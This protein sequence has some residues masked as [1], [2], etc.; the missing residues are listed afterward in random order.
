MWS[1]SGTV[2]LGTDY[3]SIKAY[4]FGIASERPVIGGSQAQSIIAG[5]GT[6]TQTVE[7][8]GVTITTPANSATG[9]VTEGTLIVKVKLSLPS[10]GTI[11]VGTP[12]QPSGF[13]ADSSLRA[14]AIT[15]SITSKSTTLK[16]LTIKMPFDTTGAVSGVSFGK[17]DVPLT[18]GTAQTVSPTQNILSP[19]YTT[20]LLTAKSQA[21]RY[22]LFVNGIGG[23]SGMSFAPGNKL[24]VALGASVYGS[25]TPTENQQAGTLAHEVGHN[26]G[27]LHGGP[28]SAPSGDTSVNCKPN[29]ESIMS[30][31]RQLPTYLGSHWK[32]DYS[33]GVLLP[34]T[35]LSGLLDKAG[36]PVSQDTSL[37]PYL[38]FIVW[39]T[40]G[41]TIVN[42]ATTNSK[43]YNFQQTV[44]LGT[45]PPDIDW[46]GTGV[47]SGSTL[48]APLSG[49]GINGCSETAAGAQMTGLGLT[50]AYNDYNDWNN[51]NF[52]FQTS[53]GVSFTGAGG[54]STGRAA[55]AAAL[56]TAFDPKA[57]TPPH[58]DFNNPILETQSEQSAEYPGLIPP[59]SLD[60]ST[61]L[62]GGANLPLKFQY[63]VS[64]TKLVKI[65]TTP[66]TPSNFI[67]YVAPIISTTACTNAGCGPATTGPNLIAPQGS[68]S[69]NT[70]NPSNEYYQFNWKTPTVTKNTKYFIN[71]FINSPALPPGVLPQPLSAAFASKP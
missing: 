22:A 69:L 55:S 60:G 37:T 13:A 51:L 25:T 17:I 30:Y 52:N 44:K 15:A 66:T 6:L 63:F 65:Q 39:G 14:G 10:G 32:L 26:L 35:E 23:P 67:G 50:G 1:G 18:L 5:A 62:K 9:G 45:A 12:T 29:Y 47:V 2:N 56:Y 48:S 3:D 70:I 49:F 41:G 27:L 40:P 53:A 57:E 16:L 38:P 43:L 68:W 59:P 4:N 7:A 71:I 11:T 61:S 34:L 20:T 31:S 8:N 46:I 24:V 36:T 33:E 42:T 64:G 21:Y 19:I 54:T 28:I 58:S